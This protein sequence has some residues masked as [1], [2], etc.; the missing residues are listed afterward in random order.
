MEGK[1]DMRVN[2]RATGNVVDSS[3]VHKI[4]KNESGKKKNA[5]R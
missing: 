1:V 4:T 2:T 5:C 3:N